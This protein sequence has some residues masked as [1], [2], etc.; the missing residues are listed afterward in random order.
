MIETL[1]WLGGGLLAMAGVLGLALMRG[2]DLR[3]STSATT[4]KVF[5]RSRGSSARCLYL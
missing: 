2:H 4:A 3:E 1:F 5:Q